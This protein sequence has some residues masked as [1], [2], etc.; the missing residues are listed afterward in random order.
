MTNSHVEGKHKE[1]WER[2]LIELTAFLVLMNRIWKQPNINQGKNEPTY[3]HSVDGT[4]IL[5]CDGKKSNEQRNGD[6]RI[7]NG[8]LF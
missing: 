5:R 3:K 6:F 4:N 7:A 2:C 1:P 8:M